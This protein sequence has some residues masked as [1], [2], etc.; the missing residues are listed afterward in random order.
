MPLVSGPYKIVT[1][2]DDTMTILEDDREN[3]ISIDRS[4]RAPGLRKSLHESTD[5]DKI[6]ES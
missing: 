5:S 4:T 3:T 6:L 1:V 2:L